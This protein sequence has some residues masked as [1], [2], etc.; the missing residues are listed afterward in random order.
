MS[1]AGMKLWRWHVYVWKLQGG[2]PHSFSKERKEKP[3]QSGKRGA[4]SVGFVRVEK[5]WWLLGQ[6]TWGGGRWWQREEGAGHL[7]FLSVL[8]EKCECVCVEG[9]VLWYKLSVGGINVALEVKAGRD[10]GA[11]SMLVG[12]T[13]CSHCLSTVISAH[14]WR[15]GGGT[16][17]LRWDR[18]FVMAPPPYEDNTRQ[19][20]VKVKL[21]P[22]VVGV[23][24]RSQRFKIV[25]VEI[26]NKEIWRLSGWSN[27][28][29]FGLKKK[30]LINKNSK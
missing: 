13:A 22:F 17:S 9:G 28:V 5:G 14:Y 6:P 30:I 23:S 21:L 8:L 18:K 29:G 11:R 16:Q 26:T 24:F 25:L 10:E 3:L 4:H 1:S 2:R 15:T 7:S 27:P 19:S 20:E 12:V